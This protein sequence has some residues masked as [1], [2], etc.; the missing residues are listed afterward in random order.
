[1]NSNRKGFRQ[2]TVNRKNYQ[3]AISLRTAK[4][5]VYDQDG[6][7]HELGL[8]SQIP[9]RVDRSPTWRGKHRDGGFGK[10]EISQIIKQHLQ[11][12]TL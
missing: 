10:Y 2:I 12:A 9:I 8:A 4:V 6:H 7:R 3:F 1:V 11:K 5:I